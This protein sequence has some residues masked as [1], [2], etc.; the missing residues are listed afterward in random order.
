MVLLLLTL[1][2]SIDVAAALD[3]F[4]RFVWNRVER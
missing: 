1:F 4:D 2:G 3:I